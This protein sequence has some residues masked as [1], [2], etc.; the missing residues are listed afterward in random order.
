MNGKKA[1]ESESIMTGK[2]NDYTNEIMLSKWI[3]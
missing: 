2:Q 1:L 3:G